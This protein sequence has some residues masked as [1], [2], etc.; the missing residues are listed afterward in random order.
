MMKGSA[1]NAYK[2]I[3]VYSGAAYADPHQLIAM[4]MD[5][6]LERMALAKGAIKAGEVAKKGELIGNTISI[7]DGLRGCLDM[8][9]ESSLSQNL[10]DLYD[11]MGRRLLQ[12]NV[13]SNV[14]IL[15]EVSSLLN[16][17]KSAWDAIPQNVRDA[18]AGRAAEAA[19]MVN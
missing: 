13:E 6:A 14:A 18:H 16:E 11:Y 7:I 8:D 15:D 5:G 17:I 10:S 12:A 9:V 19:A 4:L 2:E 1:L 3:G